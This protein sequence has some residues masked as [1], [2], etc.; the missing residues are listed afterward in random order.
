MNVFCFVVVL[1]GCLFWQYVSMSSALQLIPLHT[2]RMP[3]K[4]WAN[5][6]IRHLQD[7][8]MLVLLEYQFVPFL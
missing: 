5:Q 6:S 8:N 7:A 3:V 2:S 1:G 4:N